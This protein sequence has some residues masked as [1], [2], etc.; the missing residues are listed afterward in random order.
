MAVGYFLPPSA[1]VMIYTARPR[2][3][4]WPFAG[5]GTANVI[6]AGQQ[7]RPNTQ[8]SVMNNSSKET[9][10]APREN[11]E[12][13]PDE[14]TTGDEAND[15]CAA[16]LFDDSVSGGRR[17]IRR[18]ARRPRRRSALTSHRRRPVAILSGY[19]MKGSVC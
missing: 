7:S 3:V 4:R 15:G 16:F 10:H 9:T 19:P 8:G 6:I 18:E 5:C 12:K 2:S 13:D 11:P 17:E 14:C 1:T